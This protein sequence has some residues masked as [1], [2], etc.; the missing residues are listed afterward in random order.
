MAITRVPRS[1]KSDRGKGKR[2][3][4]L[5]LRSLDLKKK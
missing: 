5:M 4:R 3:S 2:E 1:V